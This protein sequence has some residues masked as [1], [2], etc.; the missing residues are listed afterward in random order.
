VFTPPGA[1]EGPKDC[2]DT[3]DE[4]SGEQDA[5]RYADSFVE[6]ER[7]ATKVARSS[8][9]L[10]AFRFLLS[11]SA[12]AFCFLHSAVCSVACKRPCSKPATRLEADNNRC[13][14]QVVARIEAQLEVQEAAGGAAADDVAAALH[15]LASPAVADG[16]GGV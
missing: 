13:G 12:S 8:S 5:G 4:Q 7:L 15:T 3:I 2:A 1:G 6:L 11:A 10:S 14:R 16:R 9:P